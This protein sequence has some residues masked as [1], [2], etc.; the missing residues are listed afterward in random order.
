MLYIESSSASIRNQMPG[1]SEANRGSGGGVAVLSRQYFVVAGAERTIRPGHRRANPA[2]SGGPSSTIFSTPWLRPA[3]NPRLVSATDGLAR[4]LFR[5]QHSCRNRSSRA[6]FS[7]VHTA[8]QQAV[9]KQCIAR[10]HPEKPYLT[11]T[12]QKTPNTPPRR[13]GSWRGPRPAVD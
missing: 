11:T 6:Q 10:D 8:T 9:R 3:S 5:G 4:E 7:S 13:R 2:H 1:A 12:F